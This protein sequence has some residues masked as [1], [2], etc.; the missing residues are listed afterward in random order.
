MAKLHKGI[1]CIGL[2][3]L[4]SQEIVRLKANYGGV[5]MILVASEEEDENI[6][7]CQRKFE[8]TVLLGSIHLPKASALAS[9]QG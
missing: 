6:V 7:K 4:K 9:Q 8:S 1:Y 3:P 5:H 2:F